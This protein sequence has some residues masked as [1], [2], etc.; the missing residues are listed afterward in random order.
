MIVYRTATGDWPRRLTVV[1]VLLGFA[2]LVGLSPSTGLGGDVRWGACLIIV[3][4]TVCWSFGSWATPRLT[5][6]RTRS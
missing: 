4:A 6:P 3:V 2:G 1:G 5:L